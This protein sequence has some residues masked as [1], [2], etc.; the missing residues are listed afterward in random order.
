MIIEFVDWRDGYPINQIKTIRLILSK[1]KIRPKCIK[2]II[3]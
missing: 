1:K 3:V 2:Y